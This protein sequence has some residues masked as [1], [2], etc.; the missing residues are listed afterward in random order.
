MQLTGIASIDLCGEGCSFAMEM[1]II[2]RVVIDEAN[3]GCTEEERASDDSVLMFGQSTIQVGEYDDSPVWALMGFDEAS[4]NW[5]PVPNG[6]SLSFGG[7]EDLVWFFGA[8]F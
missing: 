4:G 7:G 8:S 1:R 2:N 6:Y 5:G 3:S